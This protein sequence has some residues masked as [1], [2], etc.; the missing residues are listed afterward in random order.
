VQ[1]LKNFPAFYGTR[2]F[3]PYSQEPSTRPCPEP[4]QFQHTPSHP[5]S[6]SYATTDCQSA[7]LSWNKAPIWGLRPDFNYCLTAAGF[8]I[9]GVLS[10]ERTGLS[11]APVAGLASADNLGP[12]FL[13]TRDHILLSQIRD[14]PFHRLLRLAGSRRRYST[15][16]P[17][18]NIPS[19]LS[20]IH[21]NIAHPPKS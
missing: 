1:P 21:F 2:R 16:P 12:E 10:D 5:E 4:Y 18:G 20:Q 7:S 9:W 6:E 17:H 15:P 13:G 3:I 8:L 11:F 14:F 19:Y